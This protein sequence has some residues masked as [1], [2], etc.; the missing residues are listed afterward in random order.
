MDAPPTALACSSILPVPELASSQEPDDP[1]E[2]SLA[3]AVSPNGGELRNSRD[4]RSMRSTRY[5]FASD[6]GE[7]LAKRAKRSAIARF[8]IGTIRIT[9]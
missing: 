6:R 7:H 3:I 8:S 5:V 2:P 9:S 1:P 4:E